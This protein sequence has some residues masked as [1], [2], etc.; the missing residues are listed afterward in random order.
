MELRLS[1]FLLILPLLLHLFITPTDAFNIF[2]YFGV[3]NENLGGGNNEKSKQQTNK[4]SN[5]NKGKTKAATFIDKN[6]DVACKDFLC[7]FSLKRSN[8]K[9]GCWC[10]KH[11][12]ECPCRDG[13]F[14]CVL[15]DSHN[16]CT[17]SEEECLLFK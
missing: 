17:S 9:S 14:K 8:D 6:D 11:P 3:K 2:E 5:S 13:Q 16:F 10:V 12:S 15:K 7:D 4:N 1:P